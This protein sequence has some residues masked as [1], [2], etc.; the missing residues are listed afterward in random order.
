MKKKILTGMKATGGGLHLWNYL[1]W[2]KNFLD[3]SKWQDAYIFLADLH[4]LTTVHD[5]ETMRENRKKMLLDYFSLIPEER[6]DEVT[7]YE[8]SKIDRIND[9]TWMISSVTPYSLML[10]AHTFKDNNAKNSDINMATFN[11]P[12]L[13]TA[14]IISYDFD[15][16]PLWKDQTQHLEF[17]RDIAGN[18]NKIY[19]TEVFKMPY[20]HC[21]EELMSIPWLDGRKMSKS[22]DNDIKVFEWAKALKKKIM[23]ISTDSKWLEEPKDPDTCNVFALIKLFGTQQ[24]QNEIRAKYLAW[25]YWY[26]HAKMALLDILNNFLEPF[27]KRKAYLEENFYIIEEKLKKDNAKMNDVANDKYNKLLKITGL[28]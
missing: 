21:D 22:Y 15:I 20:I 16:V 27:R 13:M 9:I 6:L 19:K 18:F 24:E 5:A 2:L 17:A 4:S 3:F 25:N 1:G 7:I 26:W 8:Q 10:R 14:D 23:S 11:Y 12:I 28:Q